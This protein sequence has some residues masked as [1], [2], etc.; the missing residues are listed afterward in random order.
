MGWIKRNLFFVIGG[1]LALGL[2]G[3]GGYYIFAC[4]SHNQKA[5]DDLTQAVGNLESLNDEK[6]SPGN[7]KVNN[8]ET[9]KDQNKQTP[10]L[11]GF[12]GK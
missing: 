10:G 9:A 11:A 2:L 3:A 6:P 1:I 4:W 8:I 7:G 12:R 5:F